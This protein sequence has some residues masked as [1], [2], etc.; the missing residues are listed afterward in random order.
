ME[1]T[2]AT[3]VAAIEDP[4]PREIA[5][6][7]SRLVHDGTLV[8][9][10]RLP[11]VRSLAGALGVSPATVSTAWQ[12]LAEVG[13]LSSRGRAGSHVLEQTSWL[14]PRY[15]DLGAGHGGTGLDLSTGT[16]DPDLLPDLG[17]VL[18]RLSS[19]ALTTSYLDTPV[20]PPLEEHL[21]RSWP[22]P[23]QSVTV[24]DGALDAMGRCL[25][26]VLRFGDRVVVE[27]PTFPPLLD[28]LD[29]LGAEQVPVP[30][31]DEGI[32]PEALRRA[33]DLSPAAVVLQPRAHNPT[34]ISTSPDRARELAREIDRHPE[35]HRVVVIE[36]DHSGEIATAPDVSLGTH[37]DRVLHVR[38]FSKSHGP[39]LRIAALGGPTALVDRVVARRML[40]PGW[41]SRMLQQMLLELLTGSEGRDAV[42]EARHA[43]HSR[44]RRTRAAL[45]EL[46][47]PLG[48]GDGINLWLPVADEQTALLRLEAAGIRVAPG[49]PFRVA[50]LAEAP[51]APLGSGPPEQPGPH[52]RVT[53]G[54]LRE[55][56]E[57]VA[58]AL[59]LAAR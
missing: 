39:D 20:I 57:Q 52:V 28:L 43:Y 37:L 23:V 53:V 12:A 30:L 27:D 2:L 1:P 32:R 8:A 3:V 29:Q 42:A 9:G 59:V 47:I 51:A 26:L 24:V 54:R 25:E 46:G 11:T 10:T 31:D 55:D 36:D 34:G 38:S 7:I 13:V 16:P 35:G 6:A 21:R 17:A 58:R 15:R 19:R 48:A 56:V 45:A 40:G 50:P 41:T 14:P 5:A 18:S 49:H 44:Q 33:L 4:T 22:Y